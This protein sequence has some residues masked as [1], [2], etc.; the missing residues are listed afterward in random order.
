MQG[1]AGRS[2]GGANLEVLTNGAAS[3]EGVT[4]KIGLV[5]GISK[6]PVIQGRNFLE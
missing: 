2:A 3:T 6:G 1:G 5:R 4:P